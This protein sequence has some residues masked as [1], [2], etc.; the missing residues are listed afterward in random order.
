MARARRTGEV[1]EWRWADGTTVTFGARVYTYA[2]RE[3][4][5]SGTDKQG[6]N[7]RRA[8]IELEKIVQQI[9]RGTWI[10]PR[11]QLKEDRAA[12]A[13]AELGLQVDESFRAFEPSPVAGGIRSACG[14]ARTRSS[15]TSGG[16][17]TCIGASVA[18]SWARPSPTGAG[19]ADRSVDC[20]RPAV[21]RPGSVRDRRSGLYVTSRYG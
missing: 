16:S 18:T 9:E 15:T 14:S 8:E 4:V 19:A 13:M 3:K 10:P 21:R 17:A 20:G 12:T 6:W 5:A 11:L 7:R 1:T 2:R